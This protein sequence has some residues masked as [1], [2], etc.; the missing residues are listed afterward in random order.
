M[1]LTIT[2]TGIDWVQDLKQDSTDG[3][4]RAAGAWEWIGWGTGSA[5]VGTEA[6]TDT[7]LVSEG[8]EARVEATTSRVTGIF[9][10]D[11]LRSV[12]TIT[13]LSTQGIDE[14]GLFNQL[15]VAGSL[16]LE[17]GTILEVNLEE[18]DRIEFTLDDRQRA[19]G[20]S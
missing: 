8:A 17:R 5:G 6:D 14:M 15:V 12:G 11:T 9:T 16:L 13:S 10:D 1:G 4:T 18:D 7:A 19:A 2:R 3:G 20:S